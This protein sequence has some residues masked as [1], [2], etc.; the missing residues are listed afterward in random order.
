MTDSGS[1]PFWRVQ[2]VATM[3]EEEVASQHAFTRRDLNNFV[4]SID[5]DFTGSLRF[6]NFVLVVDLFR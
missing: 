4:A 6:S 2:A 3:M 5:E 1:L